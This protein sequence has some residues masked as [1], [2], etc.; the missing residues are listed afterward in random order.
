[1]ADTFP[2]TGLFDENDVPAG[3]SSVH[4]TGFLDIYQGSPPNYLDVPGFKFISEQMIFI[5]FERGSIP[6]DDNPVLF[7]PDLD[8]LVSQSHATSRN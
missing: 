3:I 1:M 6:E 2:A 7:S 4:F 8:E 5:D